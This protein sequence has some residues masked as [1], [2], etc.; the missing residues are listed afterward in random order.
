MYPTHENRLYWYY[1]CS[2]KVSA[3]GS[4]AD[5]DIERLVSLMNNWSLSLIWNPAINLGIF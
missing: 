3:G 2:E 1:C 5:H 4:G